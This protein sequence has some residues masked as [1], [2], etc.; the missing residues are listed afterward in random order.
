MKYLVLLLFVCFVFG[1]DYIP[2]RMRIVDTVGSNILVR[3]NIPLKGHESAFPEILT[4]LEE[5]RIH[6]LPNHLIIDISLLHGNGSD[7]KLIKREMKNEN[8][9]VHLIH[10]EIREMNVSPWDVPYHARDQYLKNQTDFNSYVAL[11]DFIYETMHENHNR[12]YILYV[13]CEHGI[14]RTGIVIGGYQL[15][16]LRSSWGDVSR[17]NQE[18]GGRPIWGGYENVLNWFYWR[19]YEYE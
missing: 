15:R 18:I 4:K 19:F 1:E 10:W 6:I 13:H 3:G 14:D 12:Q 5:R 2:S 11:I 7:E 17:W 16:Y 9:Q 8:P